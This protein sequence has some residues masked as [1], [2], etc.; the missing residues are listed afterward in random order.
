MIVL[1]AVWRQDTHA[2][3]MPD[4]YRVGR[5]YGADRD[6]TRENL[7]RAAAKATSC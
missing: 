5:W 7:E 6:S 2:P 3:V 4:G 1:Y